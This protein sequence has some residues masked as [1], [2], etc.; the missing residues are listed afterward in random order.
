V[1]WI[2]TIYKEITDLI[3]N[4]IIL[5]IPLTT[6][7]HTSHTT[8]ESQQ[9]LKTFCLK[10]IKEIKNKIPPKVSKILLNVLLNHNPLGVFQKYLH[11]F[12]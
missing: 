4:K 10:F 5:D 3:I 8:L 1:K 6:P 7:N 12:L 2:R 11:V 9:I